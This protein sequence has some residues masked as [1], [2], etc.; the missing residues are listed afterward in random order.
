MLLGLLEFKLVFQ[1]L[2][3]VDPGT[4]PVIVSA[5]DLAGSEMAATVMD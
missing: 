4:R 5:E 1:L 2:P 3:E